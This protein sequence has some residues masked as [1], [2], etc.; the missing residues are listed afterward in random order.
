MWLYK[1]GEEERGAGEGRSPSS[2][3]Q[4]SLLARVSS[5]AQ[6]GTWRWQFW[7]VGTNEH[8]VSPHLELGIQLGQVGGKVMERH[9]SCPGHP[10]F[11][12]R[13]SLVSPWSRPRFDGS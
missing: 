11:E 12:C 8:M 10:R 9:D 7:G 3:Q 4:M 1:K 2:S 13:Q 6:M 5:K